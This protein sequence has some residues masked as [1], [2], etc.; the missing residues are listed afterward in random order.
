M[1]ITTFLMI[2]SST[3]FMISSVTQ[4]KHMRKRK[5]SADISVW[6]VLWILAGL[7]ALLLLVIL[8]DS[9]WRVIFGRVI[10]VLEDAAILIVV[11]YYKIKNR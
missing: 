1:E 3:V 8:T 2:F 6:Y 9:N 7:S 11:V 10:S 5:S 4:I